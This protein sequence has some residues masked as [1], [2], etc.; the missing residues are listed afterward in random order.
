MSDLLCGVTMID[1]LYKVND[2]G[3]DTISSITLSDKT[4]YPNLEY[5]YGEVNFYEDKVNEVLKISFEYEILNNPNNHVID[6]QQFRDIAGPILVD[7]IDDV[8]KYLEQQNK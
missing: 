1:I 7:R 6:E 3:E 4:I 2:R 8:S 5:Q